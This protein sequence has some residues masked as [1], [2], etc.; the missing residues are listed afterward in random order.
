MSTNPDFEVENGV[1]IVTKTIKRGAFVETI[2]TTALIPL[3]GRDGKVGKDGKGKVKAKGRR[4]IIIPD[5]NSSDDS[6]S[7]DSRS[8]TSD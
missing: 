4:V 8:L 3:I 7:D 1:E 6:D 5:D 2:T